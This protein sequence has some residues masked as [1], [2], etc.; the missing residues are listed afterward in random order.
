MVVPSKNQQNEL[1]IFLVITWWIGSLAAWIA[2]WMA[3]TSSNANDSL[4]T[5]SGILLFGVSAALRLPVV[6]STQPTTSLEDHFVWLL[7]A[8]ANVNWLGYL[9]LSAQSYAAVLPAGVVGILV[10]YWLWNEMCRRD[11]LTGLRVFISAFSRNL[12]KNAISSDAIKVESPTVAIVNQ[13][14]VSSAAAS[15]GTS[16]SAT[17]ISASL[18]SAFGQPLDFQES[19][20]AEE[21]T[22]SNL[23]DS[24]SIQLDGDVEAKD[25]T[26]LRTSEE[27]I[28][29]AGFRYMAGEVQVAWEESQR[30]QTVVL[31][32]VPAFQGSP[33]VELELDCEDCSAQIQNC[34]PSGLRIQLKRS[35]GSNTLGSNTQLTNLS[36][37]AKESNCGE[38]SDGE[39]AESKPQTLA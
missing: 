27:G 24:A 21:R 4:L 8:S 2:A 17:S 19:A 18:L 25:S 1:W 20:T 36:W 12:V 6:T 15:S 38:P 22:E 10:E 33:E 39:S 30:S 3:S 16:N 28:D 13:P 9:C 7:T 26:V 11:C 34:T 32:F 35:L 31:G 29:P 37:Y 14:A 5:A 23:P